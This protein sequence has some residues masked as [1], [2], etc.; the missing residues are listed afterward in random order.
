LSVQ[1]LVGE[2][3]FAWIH[4]LVFVGRGG[5]GSRTVEEM[6]TQNKIGGGWGFKLFWRDIEGRIAHEEGGGSDG[7]SMWKS[8]FE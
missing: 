4:A 5:A 3:V 1:K 2:W 8:H 7:A 6:K